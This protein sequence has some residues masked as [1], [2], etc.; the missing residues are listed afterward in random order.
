[1]FIVPEV[2]EPTGRIPAEQLARSAELRS[3]VLAYLN[4]RRPLGTTIDV[5]Q[6]QYIWVSVLATLRVPEGSNAE[7]IAQVQRRAEETLYR[8]LNPLIGGARGD[9]WPF[10]RDLSV[11][12]IYGQLQRVPSIEFVE[13]VQL[14]IAEPGG[15]ARGGTAGPR[16]AV[17][18]HGLICS[19]QHQVTVLARED[20]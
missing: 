10:G 3:R 8:F 20:V 13:E 16:L 9:G 17:P 19:A 7:L 15:V 14:G 11:S 6:P 5:R 4:E 2:D 1:M 18:R 12:E